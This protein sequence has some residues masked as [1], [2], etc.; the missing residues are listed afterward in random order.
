MFHSAGVGSEGSR[1]VC[2]TGGWSAGVC[3][4]GGRANAL[5]PQRG[6][7]PVCI[8]PPPG[9]HPAALRPSQPGPMRLRWPRGAPP[10][11]PPF[12]DPASHP[13]LTQPPF[14]DPPS[15]PSLTQKAMML[16]WPL[17]PPAITQQPPTPR[18][19]PA[20]QPP[21]ALTL[22]P[23]A[24]AQPPCHPP[25]SPSHPAT[26][27]THSPSHPATQ[28]AGSAMLRWPRTISFN[29][30]RVSPP[31]M[32]QGGRSARASL[33]ASGAAGRQRR[34]S[35]W[36]VR[37]GWLRG[38]ACLVPCEMREALVG[39]RGRGGGA[40]KAVP[41]ARAQIMTDL[42]T[43][44]TPALVGRQHLGTSSKRPAI[45]HRPPTHQTLDRPPVHTPAR[46]PVHAPAH[47]S[48]THLVVF[49]ILG[50]DLLAGGGGG[51]R[52]KE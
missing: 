8:P 26:P 18:T 13:S 36:A 47:P 46:P 24:L 34:H 35:Q 31:C 49:V 42:G 30:L 43:R 44:G 9:A 41:P 14:A 39:G 38:Q 15:H 50:E 2:Q 33:W 16:R 11:T 6:A 5:G 20:T 45:L 28:P 27:S 1:V 40:Q 17:A 7:C 23:P 4:G 3:V 48:P 29:S 25:Q 22:R 12:A 19:R 51:G 37:A 10:R 52:T 21:P 32:H